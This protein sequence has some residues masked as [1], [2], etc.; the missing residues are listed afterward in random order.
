MFYLNNNIFRKPL[1]RSTPSPT[2]P[3]P[4]PPRPTPLP[5][6]RPTPRP[7]PTPALPHTPISKKDLEEEN[8]RKDAIEESKRKLYALPY[9]S[10]KIHY[11]PIVPLTIYQKWYKKDLQQHMKKNIEDVNQYP[12]EKFFKENK[13]KL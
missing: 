8:K 5:T 11:M 4:P 10:S 3:S 13:S 12:Y 7:T 9:R 6:T 2:P 1:H